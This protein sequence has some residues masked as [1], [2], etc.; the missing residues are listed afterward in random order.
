MPEDFAQ[1]EQAFLDNIVAVVNMEEI[2]PGLIP[3]QELFGSSI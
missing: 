3:K 2:L 1:V